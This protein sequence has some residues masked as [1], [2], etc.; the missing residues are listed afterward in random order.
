MP[1]SFLLFCL[2]AIKTKVK[3]VKLENSDRKVN[4]HKKKKVLKQGS[5]NKKDLKNLVLYLKN[6]ADCPCQQLDHLTNNNY[7]IMGRKVDKKY[8]LTSIQKWEKSS[9]ELK[10]AVKRLHTHK[11][12]VFETVFK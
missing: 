10:M 2:L 9:K 5:L 6:G 4:L 7:L 3:E 8:L 12:P 1:A 11:C